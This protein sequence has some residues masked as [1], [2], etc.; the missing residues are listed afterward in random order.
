VFLQLSINS[1]TKVVVWSILPTRYIA[2]LCA[3]V[4]PKE[5][6][7]LGTLQVKE[8]NGIKRSKWCRV[9]AFSEREKPITSTKC[10]QQAFPCSIQN[11]FLILKGAWI[12]QVRDKRNKLAQLLMELDQNENVVKTAEQDLTTLEQ[13]TQ[14]TNVSI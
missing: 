4:R 2:L 1:T 5:L 13:S 7:E 11:R 10:K 12:V 6:V 8:E 9:F 3:K 14:Q